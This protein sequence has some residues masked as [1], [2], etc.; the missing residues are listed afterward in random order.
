MMEKNDEKNILVTFLV[1]AIIVPLSM[2]KPS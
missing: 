2:T 1:V